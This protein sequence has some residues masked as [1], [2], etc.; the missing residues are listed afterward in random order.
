MKKFFLNIFLIT[1]AFSACKEK[2]TIE[3]QDANPLLVVEGELTTETDSSFVRLSLS[4]NYY[5]ATE[6]TMVKTAQVSVNG[7]PFFFDPTKNLYKPELGYVGKTDSTYNLLISYDSK[8]YTST[9][10][11]E[12]M[13]RVDSFF[14]TWKEAEGFLPAGYSVSYAGYDDRPLIKYT[15]FVNGKVDSATQ[16]DSFARQRVLWDNSQTPANKQYVFEVPFARFKSG[17]TYLAI[18]RSVDKN[19]YDF[20][21]ETNSQNPNIPGP[22]QTPPTNLPTNI[23]GGAL[24]YFATY[25][26]KRWRYT[27]K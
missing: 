19:M 8:I 21:R 12:R 22:F 7:V 9:A 26:V 25:D 3:M 10:K 4:S 11:L 23:T 20:I 1:L 5:T 13:F 27:V 17:E 2:V 16:Q 6:P 24:G 14:Q 18:F 15:Y